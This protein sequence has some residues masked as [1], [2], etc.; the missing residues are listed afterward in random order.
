MKGVIMTAIKVII[1]DCDHDNIDIESE[2]LSSPNFDLEWKNCIEEQDLIDQCQDGEAFIIQYAKITE[3][4]LANLPNLKLVVRYG[5]GVNTIDLD[6]ATRFGVQICNIPDYGTHEVADHALALLLNLTRKISLNNELI[7]EGNWN[8]LNSIPIFRHS[9][10][11]VGII[12]I[13]RIGTAFAQRVNALGCKVNA[14]D[15]KHLKCTTKKV[16]DFIQLVELDELLQSSD[17]ISIH[18]P[19]ETAVNLIDEPQLKSMKQTA[20]LINVARGGIINETALDKALTEGWIAGA[21]VDVA[22]I[23]PIPKEHPLFKHKNFISTP[24]MG[25]YSE[26]SALELKRKVAEEVKRFLNNEPV[27]YPVNTHV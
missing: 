17:I 22:E 21:A 15:P 19:L 16:P 8:F 4:V 24:H 5:V 25:W 10:Q 7:R 26:Q 27:H 2:I 20:Y 3:K 6:A 1:T 13:G 14:Y 11:T 23:E 18:C 12:G 9:E